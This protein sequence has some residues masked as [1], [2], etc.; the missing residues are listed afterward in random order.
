VRVR[1][2][3]CLHDVETSNEGAGCWPAVLCA[4]LTYEH[5]RLFAVLFD[6]DTIVFLAAWGTYHHIQ[7]RINIC[8]CPHTQLTLAKRMKP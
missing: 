4:I 6:H 1:V 5:N 2:V 3:M 8:Q 7:G